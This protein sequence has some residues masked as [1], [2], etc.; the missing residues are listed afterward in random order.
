M[1]DVGCHSTC[2]MYVPFIGVFQRGTGLHL[3]EGVYICLTGHL[4][5]RR[6]PGICRGVKWQGRIVHGVPCLL[7][8]PLHPLHAAH[9]ASVLQSLCCMPSCTQSSSFTIPRSGSLPLESLRDALT[10]GHAWSGK[11]PQDSCCAAPSPLGLPQANPL[12]PALYI[13]Q[14][15][16][17]QYFPQG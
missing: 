8:Q 14:I 5:I 3:L 12:N 2:A 11:D 7:Q 9:R 16:G 15:E 4:A 17:W 1:T 6:V 13:S 10:F